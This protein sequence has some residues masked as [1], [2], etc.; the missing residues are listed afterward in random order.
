[1]STNQ[2]TPGPLRWFLPEARSNIWLV[3]AGVL[4]NR[5]GE[6]FF[7]P[8][9]LVYLIGGY[10]IKRRL[11]DDRRLI[12]LLLFT[13]SILVMLYFHTLQTWMLYY[14]QIIFAI[15]PSAVF[16]AFGADTIR[17]QLSRKTNLKPKTIL[18][19]LGLL[20]LLVSL[21]KNLKLRDPD[22]KVFRDIGRQI[23][24]VETD[25]RGSRISTSPGLH[26]WISFYAN[27]DVSDPPC[28]QADASN[29]WLSSD[30][31]LEK[32]LRQLEHR[33]IGY[34][35]WEEKSWPDQDF[36]LDSAIVTKRLQLIGRWQHHDTGKLAL[37]KLKANQTK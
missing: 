12:C 16:A 33:E 8:Y 6:G 10:G 13:V 29:L 30:G 20:I 36:D 35:L 28:P 25:P 17:K 15:I 21:P 23:A 27:M 22:K 32:L 18:V 9:L 11:A 14:R 4:I 5:A 2:D 7:Y 24:A 31:D 19:V 34:F 1:M 37:F 26:R 3:A